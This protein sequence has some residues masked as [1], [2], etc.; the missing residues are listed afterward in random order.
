MSVLHY[1]Y[2][3]SKTYCAQIGLDWLGDDCVRNADEE[4]FT[5]E[6]TQTQVDAAMRNHLWQVKWLC[7]PKNFCW[8]ARAVMALYWL[9]GWM[10]KRGSDGR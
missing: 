4:A 5:L 8:R 10:P 2:T 7:T 9:T 1:D 6:F 3:A